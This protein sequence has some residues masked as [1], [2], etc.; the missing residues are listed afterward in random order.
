MHE[1]SIDNIKELWHRDFKNHLSED[2]LA[3]FKECYAEPQRFYHN[4]FHIGRLLE[5]AGDEELVDEETLYA[6]WFHD[7]IY[8]PK[9]EKTKNE[10][11][12][13]DVWLTFSEGMPQP[14]RDLVSTMIEATI[15]HSVP[16]GL[17]D[18]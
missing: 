13:R 8:Q 9:A 7:I 1:H 15:E 3:K 17:T 18:E 5:L 11:E 12:S 10:L 6:I 14:M 16:T 4:M 2:W